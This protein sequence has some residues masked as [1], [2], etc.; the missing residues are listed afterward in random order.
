MSNVSRARPA[1]GVIRRCRWPAGCRQTSRPRRRARPAALLAWVRPAAPAGGG[2]RR[3][4][5]DRRAPRREIQRCTV[6]PT[7]RVAA[8]E[9]PLGRKPTT[10]HDLPVFT[11]QVSCLCTV[12][13]SRSSRVGN[14]SISDG[15]PRAFSRW[16]GLPWP[17]TL[18][19]HVSRRLI[20]QTGPHRPSQ[21]PSSPREHRLAL[22]SCP[23]TGSETHHSSSRSHPATSADQ[24]ATSADHPAAPPSRHESKQTSSH[25]RE[26]AEFT[27][28]QCHAL[29][30]HRRLR[31]V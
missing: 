17:A 1:L 19:G 22:G 12:P 31:A 24:P 5:I 3:Q 16:A 14:H 26:A 11:E 10:G 6:V 2:R 23:D 25:H 27:P 15:A 21:P 13:C 18:P 28:M 4:T 8:G 9:A 30:L 29:C 7:C 20:D